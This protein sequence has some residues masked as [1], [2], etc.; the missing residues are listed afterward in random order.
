[1][2]QLTKEGQ[3]S[4]VKVTGTKYKIYLKKH[5]GKHNIQRITHIHHTKKLNI[6]RR[7]GQLHTLFYV[8]DPIKKTYFTQISQRHTN[9]AI[10]IQKI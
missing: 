1:M 4:Y 7:E 5:L 3:V 6:K 10:K 2:L 8:T 9:Q